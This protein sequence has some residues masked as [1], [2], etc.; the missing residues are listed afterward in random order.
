MNV[1][2]IVVRGAKG[3]ARE[4][5]RELTAQQ[6]ARGSAALERQARG[7]DAMT[8]AQQKEYHDDVAAILKRSGEIVRAKRK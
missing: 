6:I 2:Q 3:F 7:I 5:R 4:F 8:P 1:F